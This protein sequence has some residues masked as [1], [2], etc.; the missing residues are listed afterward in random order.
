[1][2]DTIDSRLDCG[3]EQS[4][5]VPDPVVPAGEP[6]ARRGSEQAGH[7]PRGHAASVAAFCWRRLDRGRGSSSADKPVCSLDAVGRTARL[8]D[9]GG[10]PALRDGGGGGSVVTADAADLRGL[11]A[12]ANSASTEIE[13]VQ[14]TAGG[15]IGGLDGRGWDAGAVQGRWAS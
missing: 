11:A 9:G 13:N 10:M 15:I 6:R 12:T 1:M 4:W 8:V 3:A 2:A 14:R 5:C 7:P